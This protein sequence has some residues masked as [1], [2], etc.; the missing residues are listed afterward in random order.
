MHRR[1]LILS[2]IATAAGASSLGA[3]AS[4][5]PR[6][7]NYPIASDQRASSYSFDELVSA[8]SRELGIAAEAVSYTHIRAHETRMKRGWGGGGCIKKRG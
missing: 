2:G 6:D 8:G 1:Q 5:A 4:T 7:P 3:C